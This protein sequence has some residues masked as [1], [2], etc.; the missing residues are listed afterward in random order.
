M[1]GSIK[2]RWGVGQSEHAGPNRGGPSSP[3]IAPSS[4]TAAMTERGA[5]VLF[6]KRS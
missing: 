2:E 4:M 6:Y 3:M 5:L 1:L